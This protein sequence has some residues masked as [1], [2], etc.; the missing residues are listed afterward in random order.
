MIAPSRNFAGQKKES[1]PAT[2]LA[3]LRPYYSTAVRMESRASPPPLNQ[4]A[5]VNNAIRSI[6][7]R[8]PQEAIQD[9]LRHLLALIQQEQTSRLTLEQEHSSRE[10]EDDKQQQL[11]LQLLKDDLRRDLQTEFQQQTDATL[12]RLESS[13]KSNQELR[14]AMSEMGESLRL[15]THNLGFS[16]DEEK[17]EEEVEEDV[18]TEEAAVATEKAAEVKEVEKHDDAEDKMNNSTAA[19]AMDNSEEVPVKMLSPPPDPGTE[20]V[21]WENGPK[22][23][24]DDQLPPALAVL[25]SSSSGSPTADDTIDEDASQHKDNDDENKDEDDA[26]LCIEDI[27]SSAD[28]DTSKAKETNAR[29]RSITSSSASRRLSIPVDASKN[30]LAFHETLVSRLERL[31]DAYDDIA[32]RREVVNDIPPPPSFSE[33]NNT[34]ESDF[35]GYSVSDT[36]ATKEDIC[37]LE[38]Q[39]MVVKSR[40]DSIEAFLDAREATQTSS[41]AVVTDTLPSILKEQR[42]LAQRSTEKTNERIDALSKELSSRLTKSEVAL[43]QLSQLQKDLQRETN[44]RRNNDCSVDTCTTDA[45]CDLQQKETLLSKRLDHTSSANHETP[46]EEIN[47]PDKRPITEGWMEQIDKSLALLQK[48]KADTSYVENIMATLGDRCNQNHDAI[49]QLRE[50]GFATASEGGSDSCT[51][52]SS[53]SEASEADDDGRFKEAL[54]AVEAAQTTISSLQNDMEDLIAKLDEK[55]SVDQVKALL[56]SVEASYK[57]RFA[58]HEAL[59]S[60]IDEI[61]QGLKQKM[62]RSDVSNLV[63]KSIEKARLGLIEEKDSLMIGRAPCRCIGCNSL[64]PGVS[65]S[66]AKKVNHNALPTPSIGFGRYLHA[67]RYFHVREDGERRGGGSGG[68]WR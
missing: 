57:D 31:E 60:A 37:K 38:M 40:V 24:L 10:A 33:M 9:A 17:E 42:Q 19:T 43:S 45:I 13:E 67:K 68:G 58:S 65:N 25:S 41:T 54:C 6:T 18:A 46:Q 2:A 22:E 4:T 51:S 3:H 48:D 61:H 27:I 55:P 28:D 26:S 32:K 44:G 7:F 30:K 15:L 63:S 11:Q 1:W 35:P 16:P 29:P 59:Q 12:E 49:R 36:N 50:D 8:E 53:T 62:T 66:I 39:V 21:G 5:L 64:F 23:T 47:L 56:V 34:E 52:S 14:Q 20:D